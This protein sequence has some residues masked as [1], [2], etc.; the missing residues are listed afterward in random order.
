LTAPPA[1]GVPVKVGVVGGFFWH[2]PVWHILTRGWLT[3][4]DRRRF[5]LYGYHTAIGEDAETKSAASTCDRFVPGP[6]LPERWRATIAEDAPHVLIFPDVVNDAVSAT[7]AAL[8]SA[9]VQCA[10]WRHPDTSGFPTID[11]MLSSDLMEPPDGQDHYTEKLVRL[12]N[13]SI[14]YEPADAAPMTLSRAE[15]GL[16]PNAVVYWCG[17]PL[18]KFLP[19]FDQVFARIAQN[20]EG[21][22]FAFIQYDRASEI[23]DL[24]RQ[25]LE[26]AFAALGLS[27][28]D[29]VVVL[30]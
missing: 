18:Y 17:Q 27:A 16:R 25:R 11:Y 26:L 28:A 6:L 8:R 23:T 24:F 10:A 19:Q 20:V 5:K 4:I 9:P 12:P 29:H 15:L 14:Y 7:L 3:Q 21:C 2:N 1:P 30:P 22:Q 13:L